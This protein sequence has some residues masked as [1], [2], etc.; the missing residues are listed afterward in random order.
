[1]ST[2]TLM[3]TRRAAQRLAETMDP[4]LYNHLTPEE[5]L[6]Y[7]ALRDA[8]AGSDKITISISG[9]LRAHHPLRT[10]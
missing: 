4:G 10:P 6:A 2:S 3:L 7:V 8:L 5:H 9:R 1:M